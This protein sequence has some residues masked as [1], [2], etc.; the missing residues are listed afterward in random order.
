[1]KRKV[2]I[3]DDSSFQRKQ[4]RDVIEAAGAEV[5]GEAEDGVIGLKMIKELE[6]N[7]ITLDQMMP[8]MTG[9]EMLRKMK[10][11]QIAIRTIFISAVAD[12]KMKFNIKMLGVKDILEKP[13]KENDL[14]ET[15]LKY[16]T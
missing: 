11:Q 2:L 1:M 8:N 6:P 15:V 13:F 5:I 7:L 14:K 9:E 10:T 16:H 3:I 12:E 4:I